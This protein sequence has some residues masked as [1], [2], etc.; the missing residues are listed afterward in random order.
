MRRV[1]VLKMLQKGFDINKVG[2]SPKNSSDGIMR[3]KRNKKILPKLCFHV[4]EIKTR[5]ASSSMS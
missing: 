1:F 2:R 5:K 3:S 4:E